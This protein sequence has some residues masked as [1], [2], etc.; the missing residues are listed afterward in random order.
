MDPGVDDA[1]AL[2]LA[3]SE[4]KLEVLGVTA[5]GGNVMPEQATV[6]VQTLIEQI[7]P[8]R[9]PRIGAAAANQTLRTDARHLYGPDGFCGAKFP[10]AEMAHRR[11]SIK[12]LADEIRSTPGEVTIVATGPMS[13]IASLLQAEPDIATLIGHLIILGG[14]DRVSG[15][16]T[17]AAEFNI[18]CDPDSA[19][20]VFRSPVTKTLIPLDVTQKLLFGFDLLDHFRD[21]Q[22]RTGRVLEQILPGA[23]RT[24]RQRLG[25][26]GIYLH[27]VIAV[28]AAIHPELFTI[29]RV[30][31][32]VETSGDI[33]LGATVF[34]RRRNADSQPNL[35]VATDV[36][37]VAVTDCLLRGLTSAP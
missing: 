2:C 27:D 35:D 11:P 26:E 34:D 25:L 30:H 31:G 29:D 4:P 36:D 6:N 15:N 24:Y 28:V 33:T 12:V 5:T 23:Y 3:L 7:D 1:V 16:V 9:W 37:T 8:A 14:A 20:V 22:T 32:D 21:S 18:Y 19:K 13:N 17:A 10:I